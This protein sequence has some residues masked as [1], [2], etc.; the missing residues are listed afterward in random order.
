MKSWRHAMVVL[1]ILLAIGCQAA[2]E[3]VVLENQAAAERAYESE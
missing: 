2:R 1:A 3:G